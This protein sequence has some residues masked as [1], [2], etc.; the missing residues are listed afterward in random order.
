MSQDHRLPSPI[1]NSENKSFWDAAQENR[2]I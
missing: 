1:N 2:L